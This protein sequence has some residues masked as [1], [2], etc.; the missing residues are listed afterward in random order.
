[1]SSTNP[2]SHKHL[3]D[4]PSC[5]QKATTK[6]LQNRKKTVHESL[7]PMNFDAYYNKPQ[8][9]CL[10]F[11]CYLLCIILIIYRLKYLL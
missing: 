4:I 9:S 5:S 2:L 3:N 1:M 6:K 10:S 11:R 7:K 8:M